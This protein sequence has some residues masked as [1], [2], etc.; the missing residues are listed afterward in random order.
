MNNLSIEKNLDN[1]FC[2][3]KEHLG[4]DFKLVLDH[5]ELKSNS[6]KISRLTAIEM[7]RLCNA[8]NI[9]LDSVLLGEVDLQVVID[10]WRGGDMISSRYTQKVPY[11]SRFTSIYMLNFLRSQ[12]GA[13]A[14]S[15]IGQR[16]QLKP[17]H[18][19]STNANN[20]LLLPHDICN[21]VRTY[22]GDNLLEKMGASSFSLLQSLSHV[23]N[24]TQ[25]RNSSEVFDRFI[26]EISPNYVEKNFNWT[27]DRMAP[28][29]LQVSGVPKGEVTSELRN[30]L[31]GQRALEIL[32]MGY[33][34]SIP[35]LFG[36]DQV[37][38]WQVKSISEGHDRDVYALTFKPTY[39]AF[40]MLQ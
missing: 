28:G 14:A 37:E 9:T 23:K 34:K 26:Y 32:R 25:L 4:N 22:Y 16:F 39:D 20:N 11:S 2:D 21:Y 8:L 40:P 3:L 5:C 13:S 36:I 33:I 30:N 24:L 29:F 1:F 27:I 6:R 12:I 38:I 19:K 35:K 18:F 10:H 15:L 17:C 7:N 31:S